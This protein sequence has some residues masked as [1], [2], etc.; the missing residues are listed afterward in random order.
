MITPWALHEPDVPEVIHH[1]PATQAKLAQSKP[2][3]VRRHFTQQEVLE[4]HGFSKNCRQC[5]HIIVYGHNTGTMTH[6]E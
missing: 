5:Q 2:A 1:N 6:R 4:T 3:Q